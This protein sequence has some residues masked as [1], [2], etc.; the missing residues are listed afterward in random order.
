MILIQ[1]V[2]GL[3]ATV[4]LHVVVVVE[5]W[6]DAYP[7]LMTVCGQYVVVA[8]AE[9]QLRTEAHAVLAPP[10]EAAP[11]CLQNPL[12]IPTADLY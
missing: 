11:G 3:E 6:K 7:C 5:S 2:P 4:V 10:I 1:S 9:G 8:L 12:Q